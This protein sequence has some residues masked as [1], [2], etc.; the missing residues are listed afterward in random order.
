MT[1][2]IALASLV[3]IAALAGGCAEP[4]FSAHVRDNSV[5]DIARAV[6]AA[7]SAERGARRPTAYLVTA[8]ERHLVGY[9]LEGARVKWDVP[10][11]VSS[12]VAVG[13]GFV[14][15]R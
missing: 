13:R 2:L 7:S 11:E 5:E 4:P 1:R 3:G 6:A 10:A 8:G 12:R 14:A 9:D 15:H